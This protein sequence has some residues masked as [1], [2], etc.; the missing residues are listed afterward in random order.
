MYVRRAGEREII[1]F[2]IRRECF[3][4]WSLFQSKPLGRLRKN[5]KLKV[6]QLLGICS[7]AIPTQFVKIQVQ[8][9][10]ALKMETTYISNSTGIITSHTMEHQAYSKMR[11]FNY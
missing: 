3:S 1:R 8:G 11:N 10:Y 4:F 6:V 2:K 9:A 5:N 7:V